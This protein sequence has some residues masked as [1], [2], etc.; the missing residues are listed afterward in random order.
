MSWNPKEQDA[1]KHALDRLS[2]RLGRR[3][4]YDALLSQ[5]R[6]FVAEVERGYSWTLY[7]YQN[8]L[9][10]RDQIDEILKALPASMRHQ[11][12]APLAEADRR[13]E[14][15]TAPCARPVIRGERRLGAW[16]RRVPKRAV[17]EL[18][19]DLREEGL[20]A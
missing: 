16:Y 18:E 10:V 14:D 1:L 17:G 12:S 2:G 15:A 3:V 20:I 5:W 19:D 8:D 13:F 11:L 7:E 4:H 9:S 6:S